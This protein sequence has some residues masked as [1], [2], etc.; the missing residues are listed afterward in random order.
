M[1]RNDKILNFN[2][3]TM[4]FFYSKLNSVTALLMKI[5]TMSILRLSPESDETNCRESTETK[6]G[7]SMS[8]KKESDLL[9][10]VEVESPTSTGILYL[11]LLYL[12]KLAKLLFMKV[13]TMG[14]MIVKRL[15]V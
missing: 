8:E 7:E 6:G 10:G 12:E 2:T 5:V 13:M 1:Y 4:C 9:M 14:L 3:T 11:M 15:I